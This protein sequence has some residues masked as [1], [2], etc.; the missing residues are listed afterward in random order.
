[1]N[2]MDSIEESHNICSQNQ[3]Y[4]NNNN[5]NN[6]TNNNN[7]NNHD[8]NNT[9][10]I[11]IPFISMTISPIDLQLTTLPEQLAIIVIPIVPPTLTKTV[12]FTTPFDKNSKSV[13][14][15]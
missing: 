6:H 9:N 1:M 5:H 14:E 10:N 4:N 3:L 12:T 2:T 13:Q 11:I 7:N 8:N 15:S